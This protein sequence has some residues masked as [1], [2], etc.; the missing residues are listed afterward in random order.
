MAHALFGYDGPCK[1][2]HGH[3]YELQVTVLGQPSTDN[4][5]PKFGMVID[6][7]DLKKIVNEEIISK[8]DHALVLNGNSPHKNLKNLDDTFEKIIYTNYQPTCENMLIDFKDRIEKLLP[9]Y[10]KLHSMSLRETANS[11]AEWYAV[12]N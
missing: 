7:T 3:S 8:M 11:F 6:F 10:V 5:N 12:D 1:N 9:T 4:S 2:I